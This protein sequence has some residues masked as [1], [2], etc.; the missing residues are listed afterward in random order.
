MAAR[1]A[2]LMRELQSSADAFGNDA[3]EELEVISH[4]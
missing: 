1:D 2:A 3:V 4:L